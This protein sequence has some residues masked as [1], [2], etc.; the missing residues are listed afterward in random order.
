MLKYYNVVLNVR[1][2]LYYMSVGINSDAIAA[3]II[4]LAILLHYSYK[5]LYIEFSMLNVFI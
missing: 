4:S 3:R 2:V 5:S 1:F